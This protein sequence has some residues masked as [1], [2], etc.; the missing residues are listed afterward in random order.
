MQ[1]FSSDTAQASNASVSPT[2]GKVKLLEPFGL[3]VD[4]TNPHLGRAVQSIRLRHAIVR[5]RLARNGWDLGVDGVPVHQ[6]DMLCTALTLSVVVLDSLELLGVAATED[7]AEDFY[8]AWRVTATM[9]GTHADALP[10]TLDQARRLLPLLIERNFGTSTEGTELTKGMLAAYAELTPD[11]TPRE[12]AGA[13]RTMLGNH[14]ADCAGVPTA[15]REPASD[16]H[17]IACRVG[18][19][20]IHNIASVHQPDVPAGYINR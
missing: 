17:G 14:L 6:E 9:L 12:L 4:I 19:A 11:T 5:D 10:A 8:H 15:S 2:M 20:F 16:P 7:Q 3:G 1:G 13:A 18:Q